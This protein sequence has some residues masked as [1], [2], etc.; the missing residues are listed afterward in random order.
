MNSFLAILFS[1]LSFWQTAN[2][3]LLLTIENIQEVKGNIMVSVRNEKGE[4]LKYYSAKITQKPS[5]E[6][7]ITLP[8]NGKYTLA[9]FHDVNGNKKLDTGF[10]GQPVEP[11]G[12]S[13]NARETFSEPELK[14]QLFTVE[15]NRKMSIEVK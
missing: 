13:N 4:N 14:D 7:K 9:V 15:G 11:Y 10:F 3:T 5:Q 1:A 6:F 12:F 8:K 2:P